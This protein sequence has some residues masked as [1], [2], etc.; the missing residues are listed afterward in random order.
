MTEAEELLRE[1]LARG[2]YINSDRDLVWGKQEDL[3][4]AYCFGEELQ[5][6]L[7]KYYENKHYPTET[8]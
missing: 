6:R 3:S 2:F 8:A 4:I 5:I 7:M 1:L